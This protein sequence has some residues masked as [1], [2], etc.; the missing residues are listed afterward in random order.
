MSGVINLQVSQGQGLCLLLRIHLPT[1]TGPGILLDIEWVLIELKSNELKIAL[2]Q[3][4]FLKSNI[5][6]H[7]PVTQEGVKGTAR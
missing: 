4:H 1:F 7:R 3:T 6:I 2:I 5:N